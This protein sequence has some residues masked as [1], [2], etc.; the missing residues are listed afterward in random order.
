MTINFINSFSW[1][2]IMKIISWLVPILVVGGA[3]C[4]GDWSTVIIFSAFYIFIYHSFNWS[5][6]FSW[7]TVMKIIRW[8]GWVVPI[9]ITSLVVFI[10][11]ISGKGPGNIDIDLDSV[12]FCFLLYVFIYFG[13]RDIRKEMKKGKTLWQALKE[14]PANVPAYRYSD[15]PASSSSSYHSSTPSYSSTDYVRDIRYSHL[16]CNIFYR[17]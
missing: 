8:K 14:R 4:R 15:W 11:G 1:R 9:L 16:S 13:M 7:K 3:A 6:I 2:S 12:I 5:S 17:K 10:A